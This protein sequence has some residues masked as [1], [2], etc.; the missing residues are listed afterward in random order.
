[1]ADEFHFHNLCDSAVIEVGVHHSGC[2]GT[3]WTG[4][5][6]K[7]WG[8][9][10][11]AGER[12]VYPPAYWVRHF[13]DILSW[14]ID[15]ALLVA[16]IAIICAS[17]GMAAPAVAEALAEEEVTLTAAQE[18]IIEAARSAENIAQLEERF[19]LQ[20]S[21]LNALLTLAGTTAVAVV[22]GSGARSLH[23]DYKVYCSMKG[24]DY[25]YKYRHDGLFF[26]IGGSKQYIPVDTAWDGAMWELC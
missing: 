9:N 1:M 3:P 24:S 6:P 19:L 4:G 12:R 5:L 17:D 25:N 16:D 11:D 18:S 15:G 21:R 7:C 26:M 10:I 8:A 22:A 14:M 23:G 13:K 2:G 20:P